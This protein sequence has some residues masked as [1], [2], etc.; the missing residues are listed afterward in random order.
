[1]S[2]L[3]AQ[4]LP[5]GYNHVYNYWRDY[6]AFSDTTKHLIIIAESD[7]SLYMSITDKWDSHR[8]KVKTN[9]KWNIS[10][11]SETI[12]GDNAPELYKVIENIY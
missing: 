4:W 1:M 11:Y 7:D 12:L 8:L 3:F 9:N 10:F 6:K 2:N 5:A